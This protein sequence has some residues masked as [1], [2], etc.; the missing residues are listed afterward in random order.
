[1]TWE[2][3]QLNLVFESKQNEQLLYKNSGAAISVL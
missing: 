1:M 3:K 2:Q